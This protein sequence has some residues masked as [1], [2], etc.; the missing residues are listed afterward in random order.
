Y[1]T[2][3]LVFRSGVRPTWLPDEKF[4]Y[5]LTTPAGSE[6]VLIDPSKGS[7]EP[8]FDHARLAS[9]LS[10][11]AASSYKPFD[12]PFQQF[13]LSSDGKSITFSVGTRRW[14][15]ARQ[16]TQCS[17]STD[18]PGGQRGQRGA[19]AGTAAAPPIA[20]SPDGKKAAFIR[21]YNLWV[22]DVATGQEK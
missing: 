6:F 1:N 4:W 20:L 13:D 15:G 7:R 14:T 9:A 11:A 12:L 8:A 22:R 18:T 10:A 5:R 2:N 16:G 3:P 21:N 19:G 17:A